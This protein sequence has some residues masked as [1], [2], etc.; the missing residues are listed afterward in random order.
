MRL[1]KGLRIALAALTAN[2]LRAILAILGIVVGVAAVIVMM[3]VGEGARREVLGKIQALGTNLIIVS[4]GQVKNVAGR[5]QAVGSVTT[6]DLRDARAILD[7]C[8]AVARVVPVQSRRMAVKSGT[9]TTNSTVVG[10]GEEF[11]AVRQFRAGAGRF[12]DADE[13]LGAQRVAVV[14][15]TVLT[16]LDLRGGVVGETIRIGNVPFEVIGILERKGLNYA[17]VDEDDQIV[18]PIST[19]LR[20]LFNVTHLNSLYLQSRDERS[21]ALASAQVTELLRERHRIKPGLADDFMVQTQGEILATAQ[22]TGQ[23]FSL[24]LGSVAGISLL[25]GGIGILA[26]MVISVRERT[27]E[28]GVRR[29]VGARQHDILL[30]FV[31]E[32]TALSLLGGVAGIA[33]GLAGGVALSYATGWPTAVSPLAIALAFGVSAAIG[34]FFGAYPARRA[35]RLDP[36]VA[37]RAE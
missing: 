3:A 5:P 34:V 1:L 22:E 4:A 13:V 9:G 27:R 15:Q 36:I 25:V 16:N 26:L 20:R 11:A 35:A 8:S 30:Q 28:I 2:R 6:L 33:I 24:L 23:T 37:L 31:M 12:F 14:G 7:E 29:A 10:A 19:A 18:I 21:M 17:G 32:A